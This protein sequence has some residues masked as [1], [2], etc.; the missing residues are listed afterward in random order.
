MPLTFDQSKD[1]IAQRVRQFSSN[2]DQY[3]AAS[4]KEAHARQEFIHP[5]FAALGRDAGEHQRLQRLIASTDQQIDTLV[6]ELY[7]LTAEE[8][9]IVEG[10]K[11]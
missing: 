11:G 9:A 1:E 5:L 6:C 7:G 4:Y 3:R 2:R 10:R 8:I